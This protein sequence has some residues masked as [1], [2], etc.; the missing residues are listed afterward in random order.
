MDYHISDNLLSEAKLYLK[1]DTEDD[2][3]IVS[4]LLSAALGVVSQ[5]TAYQFE[6]DSDSEGELIIPDLYKAQLFA[7][8]SHLYEHRK[9][10][11]TGTIVQ[12]LPFTWDYLTLINRVE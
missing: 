2:D 11:I 9:I 10:V 7:Y 4:L 3:N 8:L 6:Y 5:V 12:P 1:I